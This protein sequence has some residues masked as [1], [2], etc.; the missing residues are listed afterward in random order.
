MKV[1]PLAALTGVLALAPL[2]TGTANAA[3]PSPAGEWR[4]ADG[5]AT[6]RIEKCGPY[7][8]GFVASANDPGKDIRNP[9]PSKRNRSVLG[10][11]ILFNLKSDGASGYTGET[12]NADD[13]QIYIATVTSLGDTLKIRGCVPNGGI[14][15]SETW[16][17]VHK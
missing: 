7:Y 1:L 5:G 14:C 16:T 9:D 11:E 12:Y 3:P 4:V 10:I 6:V 15:G 8:C 2:F 13:G 17:L